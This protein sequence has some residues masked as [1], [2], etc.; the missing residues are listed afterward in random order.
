LTFKRTSGIGSSA[1]KNGEISKLWY[2]RAASYQKECLYW[3]IQDGTEQH[4]SLVAIPLKH[5][6]LNFPTVSVAMIAD[7]SDTALTTLPTVDIWQVN[8]AQQVLILP[9]MGRTTF[10]VDMGIEPPPHLES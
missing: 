5:G 2:V 8:A 9:K 3:P 7:V 1:E 4:F 6:Y 10:S